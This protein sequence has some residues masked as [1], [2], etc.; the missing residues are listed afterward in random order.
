[1]LRIECAIVL[2]KFKNKSFTFIRMIENYSEN[3]ELLYGYRV[4]YPIGLELKKVKNEMC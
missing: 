2:N 3:I 4:F 1:M